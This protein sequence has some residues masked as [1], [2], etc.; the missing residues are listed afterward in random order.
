MG[1]ER[2]ETYLRLV[3]ERELRRV[4][5]RPADRA[6][7]PGQ[8]GPRGWAGPADPRLGEITRVL[9]E[10]GLVAPDSQAPA[11]LAALCQQLGLP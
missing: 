10:A 11:Q 5:H 6:G 4:I 7:P 9:T 3:A 1:D 8:A 2:A